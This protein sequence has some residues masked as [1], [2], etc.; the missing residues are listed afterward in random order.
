MTARSTRHYELGG[1]RPVYRGSRRRLEKVRL[2]DN[3]SRG[4]I[5]FFLWILL[6]LTVAI[7]WVMHHPPSDP[8]DA[9][10]PAFRARH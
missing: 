2:R 5:L 6:I 9:G 10:E 3:W 4:A 1:S 7:P 8:D